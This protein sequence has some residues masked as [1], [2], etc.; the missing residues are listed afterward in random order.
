MTSNNSNVIS[1]GIV[2]YSRSKLMIK[3]NSNIH[4]SDSALKRHRNDVPFK[5]SGI[6]KHTSRNPNKWKT[7][8]N[9]V[10]TDKNCTLISTLSKLK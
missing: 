7:Q 6:N 9:S 2:N 5:T 8:S 3:N 10:T 4:I 1:G